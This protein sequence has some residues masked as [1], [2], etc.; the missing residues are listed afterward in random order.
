MN[1]FREFLEF[2]LRLP[3]AIKHVTDMVILSQDEIWWVR[4]AHNYVMG[5]NIG[6]DA[7][8]LLRAV[9]NHNPDEPF[10]EEVLQEI[11]EL[12]EDEYERHNALPA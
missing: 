3:Y 4:M 1:T 10:G 5:L 9:A 8:P 7:H 6:E 11:D 2:Y 12:V